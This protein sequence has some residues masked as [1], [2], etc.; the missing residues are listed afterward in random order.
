MPMPTTS[1][2]HIDA[3][4]T[5]LSIAYRQEYPPVSDVIFPRV[6][7]LQK[8]DKFFV[9]NKAD[10]WRRWARKRA[11]GDSFAEI[12][13]RLSTD[14]F[15]CEQYAASFPI[16]FETEDNADA[17]LDLRRTGTNTIND[18]LFL[19][20]DITFAESFMRT[21]IWGT[22]KTG[23]TD[24]TKWSD[25]TSNPAGDV[26]AARRV[27][28]RAV[29]SNASMKIVATCGNIVETAL[30]NHPDAIDRIKYTQA[31]TVDAVR[32]VLAAWLGVDMLLVN[33]REY[34]TSVEGQDGTYASVFDDDLLVAAV[35]TGPGIDVPSAGYTFEWN[36]KGRGPLYVE[37]ILDQMRDR[38]II[39][40]R[41]H[42]DQ[43]LVAAPLG[44]FFSDCVD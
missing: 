18:T 5:D 37:E 28:R 29:G 8:S 9:W 14:N 24:F 44:Y 33:D 6:T 26:L 20:K 30:I 35:P 13:L 15:D 43:K 7:V 38:N 1:D 23:G 40:G 16:P 4:L 39:R 42:Y 10:L 2:V 31:A 21:G 41:A 32:Q 17:V 12:A 11:P 3:A 27:L 25:A 36:R 19:E 22:D 34:T